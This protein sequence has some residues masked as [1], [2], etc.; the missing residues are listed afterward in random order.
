MDWRRRRKNT[1][2]GK[3]EERLRRTLK[4]KREKN[5]E[6]KEGKDKRR[7]AVNSV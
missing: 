6:A 1:E 3:A 7:S 2:T 4:K 5:Q